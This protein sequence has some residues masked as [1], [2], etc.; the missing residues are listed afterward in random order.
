M[1][2]IILRMEA[3]ERYLRNRLDSLEAELLAVEHPMLRYENLQIDENHEAVLLFDIYFDDVGFT[4]HKFATRNGEKVV[5]A[6]P[7]FRARL[8]VGPTLQTQI[9]GSPDN[10]APLLNDMTIDGDQLILRL[11]DSKIIIFLGEHPK[12]LLEITDIVTCYAVKRG[13]GTQWVCD[14]FAEL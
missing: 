2:N 13:L 8:T 3:S 7:M 12:A 4:P 10:A 6:R 1:E 14:P 11:P 5:E 9:Q